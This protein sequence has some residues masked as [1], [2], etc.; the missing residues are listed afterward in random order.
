MTH[1]VHHNNLKGNY[2]SNHKS[3][4]FLAQ[5][6]MLGNILLVLL[7][8]LDLLELQV[9]VALDSAHRRWLSVFSA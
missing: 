1:F 6:K 8:L 3:S 7:V 4:S 9:T 5:E 2:L